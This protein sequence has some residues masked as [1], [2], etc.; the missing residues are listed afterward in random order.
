MCFH[1]KLSDQLVRHP[2]G[3]SMQLG[4]YS[5]PLQRAIGAFDRHS[6]AALACSFQRGTFTPI[7]RSQRVSDSSPRPP[8]SMM[9]GDRLF[10][11]G[12]DRKVSQPKPANTISAPR[13]RGRKVEL[14]M[15]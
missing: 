5:L 11:N 1:K 15:R 9:Y 13:T 4:S 12:G 3:L 8:G 6:R 10:A 7:T 14:R 2:T